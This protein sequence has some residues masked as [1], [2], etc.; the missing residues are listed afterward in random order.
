L[1]VYP[2]LGTPYVAAVV[3]VQRPGPVPG[4]L[5]LAD[6][7]LAHLPLCNVPS[8]TATTA[9]PAM[10]EALDPYEAEE[11]AGRAAVAAVL[12][13]P[14]LPLATSRR[15][16]FGWRLPAAVWP[17]G[18]SA[19]DESD[20]YVELDGDGVA[21]SAVALHPLRD[22]WTELQALPRPRARDDAP[23]RAQP[24]SVGGGSSIG[25]ETEPGSDVF[26]P[27]DL[28]IVGRPRVDSDQ[29]QSLSSGPG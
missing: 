28:T 4:K 2:L 26:P 6:V 13:P 29:S 5:D 27:D 1:A 14:P 25:A 7:A 21:D 15:R 10:V 12:P 11:A 16:G 24:H 19:R 8:G 22:V 20:A 23:A 17:R 18:G 9:T 3:L